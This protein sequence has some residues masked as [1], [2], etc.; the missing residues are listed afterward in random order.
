MSRT[1]A[2][3]AFKQAGLNETMSETAMT[4]GHGFIRTFKSIV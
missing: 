3:G 4:W 2:C 1:G